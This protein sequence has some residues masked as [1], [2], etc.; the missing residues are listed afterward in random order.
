M[1]RQAVQIDAPTR[2]G[3]RQRQKQ[4]EILLA[5]VKPE[6]EDCGPGLR[7]ESVDS[8]ERATTLELMAIG[9]DLLADDAALAVQCY[10]R[11][12]NIAKQPAPRPKD[13]FAPDPEPERR[14]QWWPTEVQCRSAICVSEARITVALDPALSAAGTI[15]KLASELARLRSIAE[16]VAAACKRQ[17]AHSWLLFNISVRIYG[18]VQDVLSRGLAGPSLTLLLPP[19]VWVV[20]AVDSCAL[21]ARTARYAEWRVQLC[22]LACRCFEAIGKPSAAAKFCARLMERLVAATEGSDDAERLGAFI[23]SVFRSQTIFI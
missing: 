5:E 9:A 4:A 10:T 12:Y 23:T 6:E 7:W 8:W 13:P 2:G 17:G 14:R 1:S 20:G 18:L 3:K 19:L 11:A 22:A 16:E 21:L 15:A